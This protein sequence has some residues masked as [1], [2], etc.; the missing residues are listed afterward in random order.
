MRVL[1]LGSG[2]IGVASA[3]YLAAQGAEVTVLDR[4]SGLRKKPVLVMQDK[5]HRAIRPLGLH[6]GFH[7]KRLNGC[8]NI[9]HL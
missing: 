8:S 9:M 1:V 6:R 2:V 4:Q 7:L 3:Y 5:F